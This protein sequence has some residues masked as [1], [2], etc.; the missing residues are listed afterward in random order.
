MLAKV[1]D[2]EGHEHDELGRFT[3]ES[4]SP[5]KRREPKNDYEKSI[6]QHCKMFVEHGAKIGMVPEQIAFYQK[7]LDEG[8]WFDPAHLPNQDEI[9]EPRMCFMNSLHGMREHG[10]DYV[11]GIGHGIIP[12]HHAWNAKPGSHTARDRTW[13]TKGDDALTDPEKA[14][15]LGVR[16]PEDDV[17]RQALKYGTYG[18]FLKGPPPEKKRRTR[19]A[20]W[21]FK[22]EDKEGNKHGDD[23]R[24]SSTSGRAKPKPKREPKV[25]HE[26]EDSHD[27][28]ALVHGKDP[29]RAPKRE[30]KFA[31][32]TW[33][34][35][36]ES[37]VRGVA[38]ARA[39]MGNDPTDGNYRYFTPMPRWDD[40]G[41]G[42][43]NR[44]HAGAFEPHSTKA[45]Q[46]ADD[47]IY[48]LNQ[49]MTSAIDRL[50][51]RGPMS[52]KSTLSNKR[53]DQIKAT[54]RGAYYDC[55]RL[56]RLFDAFHRGT[57][58]GAYEHHLKTAKF[59]EALAT[60]KPKNL[61]AALKL[62]GD[63]GLDAPTAGNEYL[64]WRHSIHHVPT[65]QQAN[66]AGNPQAPTLQN[67]ADLASSG[68]PWDKPERE[69][70]ELLD[71]ALAL[72]GS[73]LTSIAPL[74][75]SLEK[76]SDY[77]RRRGF[78]G[79]A[80]PMTGQ[81]IVYMGDGAEQDTFNPDDNEKVNTIAHEIAHAASMRALAPEYREFKQW[82]NERML[83]Y[84]PTREQCEEN[85]R[86]LNSVIGKEPPTHQDYEQ[87]YGKQM[88]TWAKR[89][90]TLHGVNSANHERGG[91]EGPEPVDPQEDWAIG[92]A[93]EL[94]F[95]RRA[96][97]VGL[98]GLVSP[99]RETVAKLGEILSMEPGRKPAH[100][101]TLGFHEPELAAMPV[102]KQSAA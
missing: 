54:Y 70:Q 45:Y 58:R 85:L 11:E 56:Q 97:N 82:M 76:V 81:A 34:G 31:G 2:A 64:L 15:Y 63:A 5:P 50:E 48:A 14:A 7:M 94:M 21:L 8:E 1:I 67:F 27:T 84:R 75:V 33:R 80:L 93:E 43:L 44:I 25:V 52:A 46:D 102:P 12:T 24:F 9:G 100:G 77:A 51:G 4:G 41:E 37:E 96:S 26:P 35:I 95:G 53:R 87:N 62:A 73:K 18:Y 3:G 23:G 91:A 10:E 32:R 57:W 66:M 20:A 6:L 59:A 60:R 88:T 68:E 39:R 30:E 55:N 101:T 47:D 40:P 28:G 92:I 17:V 61:E 78:A 36:K 38:E 99:R 65:Q 16:I 74:N 22:V 71:R 19:K 89:F 98:E 90:L 29:D 83:P 69:K 86:R 13:S 79:V 49:Y 72:Y 42:V